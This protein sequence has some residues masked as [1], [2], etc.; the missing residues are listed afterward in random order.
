M[1][2][3]PYADITTAEMVICNI[4]CH[5]LIRVYFYTQ[6]FLTSFSK[7]VENP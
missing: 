5:G 7:S 2:C 4:L 1:K 3:Q 6:H